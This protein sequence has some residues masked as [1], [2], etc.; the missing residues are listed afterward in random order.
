MALMLFAK[1][2]LSRT[3]FESVWSRPT[4]LSTDC[5]DKIMD[6]WKDSPRSVL[7][8]STSSKD[9]EQLKKLANRKQQFGI[10]WILDEGKVRLS[11]SNVLKCWKDYEI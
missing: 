9:R 8:S 1:K 11:I 2:M 6:I 4:G 7:Q 5:T 10:F 3:D